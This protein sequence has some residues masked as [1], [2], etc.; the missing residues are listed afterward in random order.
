MSEGA[1]DKRCFWI[2]SR[3]LNKLV[4]G[5]SSTTG[6]GLG[7]VLE[8]PICLRLGSSI[9]GSEGVVGVVGVEG[10]EG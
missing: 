10:G 9:S 1:K 5:F 8:D 2:T 3:L 6:N 4:E 7:P